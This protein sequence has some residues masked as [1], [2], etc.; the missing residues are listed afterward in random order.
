MILRRWL[1]TFNYIC[2]GST[3]NA[4]NWFKMP[5]DTE[6]LISGTVHL[7]RIDN[8]ETTVAAGCRQCGYARNN[9]HAMWRCKLCIWMHEIVLH[10]D[11]EKRRFV[12]ISKK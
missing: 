8:W 2:P 9:V 12:H 1:K 5:L 10:I 6:I 3:F 11:N 7:S 4:V